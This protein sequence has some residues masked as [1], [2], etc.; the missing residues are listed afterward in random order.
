MREAGRILAETLEIVVSHVRPGVIEGELDE[1]ARRDFKNGGVVP[2]FLNYGE[3]PYPAAICVSVND[4]IVHGIPGDREIAEGD[5]VSIDIGC[6]RKGFV[7]DMAVTVG[8]GT[9][10][11][12]AQKLIDVPRDALRRGIAVSPGGPRTRQIRAALPPRGGGG[13]LS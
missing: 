11:P 5:V 3:P 6:T 10:A 9:L 4:E 12:Q 8:A 13:G 7:A 2:T 1:I